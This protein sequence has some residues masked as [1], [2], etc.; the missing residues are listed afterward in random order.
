M[1]IK[2]SRIRTSSGAG[3]LLRHLRNADDNEEVNAIQGTA[4]DMHDAVADAH[5]FGRTYCLRHW[6]IA[7]QLAI[8][9]DQFRQCAQAIADE[10]GFDIEAGFIV[11]HKKVRAIDG[12]ADRHW[13][14]VVPEVDPVSGRVLDTR[15]DY[16]RHEK[17]GRLLEALFGHPMTAGPHDK[18]VIV[19]L[20]AEGHDD[21]ADCVARLGDGRERPAE[22]YT[23][24]QHQVAKRKGLDLPLLK[25]HVAD[26]WRATGTG[27]DFVNR[28]AE[29]GLV[30]APGDKDGIWVVRA[31]D[32]TF[33]GAAHRLARVR[34]AE[35]SN[36]MESIDDHT[37]AVGSSVDPQG[38][39]RTQETDGND[40][41]TGP[42]GGDAD[43]ERAGFVRRD[44]G[45]IVGHDRERHR[46]KQEE[47][48]SVAPA[49]RST[50]DRQRSAPHDRRE[51]IASISAAGRDLAALIRSPIGSGHAE[52]VET[53]IAQI[54]HAARTKIEAAQSGME[55]SRTKL[56][57]MVGFEASARKTADELVTQLRALENAPDLKSPSWLDRMR[58]R[59]EPVG[60]PGREAEIAACR[61]EVIGAERVLASAV[62]AV[63]RAEKDYRQAQTAAQEKAA[64]IAKDAQKALDQARVTRHLIAR[65]PRLVFSGLSF[66]TWA[67]GKVYRTR[68]RYSMMNTQAKNIWGLP[69]DPGY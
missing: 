23:T 55:I 43:G 66:V 57:A 24:V 28:L 19:A 41:G 38:Y 51:L 42:H 31:R 53:A 63:A 47:P 58:G 18:A 6:I 35:F 52:R 34:R 8:D 14:F 17:L 4:Q 20:R 46:G 64:G 61:K 29:H 5:R 3:S 68:K 62:S 25:G 36:R 27:H 12:V 10:F 11:E 60:S 59:V 2:S 69:I 9:A 45:E 33:I 54:E 1:L 7:P 67:G 40:T 48:G 49:F 16:A 65:Y 30:I 21:V 22:A 15:N 13:H 39:S 26:A 37:T 32:G 44:G 50:W 56:D